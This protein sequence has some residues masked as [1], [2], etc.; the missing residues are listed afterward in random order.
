MNMLASPRDCWFLELAGL[1]LVPT[2]C[3]R[4]L[5]QYLRQV[6]DTHLVWLAEIG[7]EAARMFSSSNSEEP[8][9]MPKAPSQKNRQRRKRLSV[10]QEESPQP[11]RKRLSRRRKSSL[12]LRPSTRAYLQR[13][14]RVQNK[15]NLELM[16]PEI[17]QVSPPRPVTSAELHLQKSTSK[18]AE[19]LSMTTPSSPPQE[20]SV[21]KSPAA[22]AAS[23]LTVPDTPR[24]EDAGEG[25]AGLK[26]AQ[27]ANATFIISEESGLEEAG[28][29]AQVPEGAGKEPPQHLRDPPATLT[30][31]RLSRRSVRRSLMGRTSLTRRT[32]LLEKCSLV[33]KRESML[34]RSVTSRAARKSSVSSS[35]VEA[36]SSGEVPEEEETVLK[37]GPPPGPCTPSKLNPQSPQMSLRSQT[38][39]RNEQ[40]QDPGSNETNLQ[41]NEEMQKPTDILQLRVQELLNRTRPG[42]GSSKKKV[43]PVNNQD[44]WP[45]ERLLDSSTTSQYQQ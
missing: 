25:E 40:P 15:A 18:P 6:D 29:P 14:Q 44:A 33:T 23:G 20:S 5:A 21:A 28:D 37:T 8:E 12:R 13:S 10:L 43:A 42:D 27:A 3:D 17:K 34:R 45:K 9:L 1:E 39:G 2:E 31:S 38:A 26:A 32:S 22:P 41:K 7:E 19:E 36:S 30:G 16:I 35:C 24:A 4:R 11:G